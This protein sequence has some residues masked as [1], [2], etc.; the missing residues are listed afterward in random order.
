[1]NLEE[2]VKIVEN[3]NL[4][5][6]DTEEKGYEM[7]DPKDLGIAIDILVNCIKKSIN[8]YSEINR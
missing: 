7:P 1:M 5:R 4:W 8:I 2:A 6:R 3:Y